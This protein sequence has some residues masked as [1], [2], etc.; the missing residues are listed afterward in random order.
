MCMYKWATHDLKKMCPYFHWPLHVYLKVR[1]LLV[2]FVLSTY[3]MRMSFIL[4]DAF[5][6]VCSDHVYI[7]FCPLRVFIRDSKLLAKLLW[8]AGL[9]SCIH[10]CMRACICMYFPFLALK[11]VT[12]F[13]QVVHIFL[14]ML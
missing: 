1:I 6:Y 5:Q 14:S 4:P 12:E 9:K 7:G 3:T 2:K 10:R 11:C 8:V 13:L